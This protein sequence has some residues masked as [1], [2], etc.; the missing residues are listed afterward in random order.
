MREYYGK[1]KQLLEKGALIRTTDLNTGEEGIYK[2]GRLILNTPCY[3]EPSEKKEEIISLRPT[4]VLFGFGHI[5]KSVY[6]M[7]ERL[8]FPIIVFDDRTDIAD[9]SLYEKAEIII[10]DYKSIFNRLYSF[11]NPYFLIFTHGHK[12]DEEALYY[13]LKNYSSR[14]VGMIGSR[15][16]IDLTYSNLEKRGIDEALLKSVHAPIGI[17]INAQSP[18]EIAISILAEVIRTYREDKRQMTIDASMLGYLHERDEKTILV[19][20]VEKEGSGPREEGAEMAVTE[21]DVFSTIGGGAI[22]VE[23]IKKAREMLKNNESFEIIDFN[24]EKDGTLG[25]ACGGKAKIMLK[26]I[27]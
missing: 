5:G 3:E 12:W 24:L 8:E 27:K 17:E 11:D 20:I 2:S 19:R 4:L 15:K 1:L 14:Y 18:E 21:S 16:K 23:C 7:A 22:E 10:D 25:M 6:H 9:D 26:L 13:V